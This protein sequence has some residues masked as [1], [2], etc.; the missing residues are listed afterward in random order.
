[1]HLTVAEYLLG[2]LAADRAAGHLYLR[3]TPLRKGRG[4]RTAAPSGLVVLTLPGVVIAPNP[5][6]GPTWLIG[7]RTLRT[8]LCGMTPPRLHY[9]ADAFALPCWV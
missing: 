1:M 8:A 3:L 7:L 2:L 5:R 9:R 4:R 6:L